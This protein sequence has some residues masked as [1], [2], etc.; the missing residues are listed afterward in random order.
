[1]ADLDAAHLQITMQTDHPTSQ[2]IEKV[3]KALKESLTEKDKTTEALN[4]LSVITQ[5][6]VEQSSDELEGYGIKQSTLEV[7]YQKL[8][9]LEP[10]EAPKTTKP[11][12]K[13]TLP[14]VPVS[15]AKNVPTESVAPEKVT[16][17]S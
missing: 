4:R 6:N 12:A 8:R 13:R 1:M 7:E 5:V 3:N 9:G 17:K 2:T 10:K 15:A 11:A 14:Q 16:E